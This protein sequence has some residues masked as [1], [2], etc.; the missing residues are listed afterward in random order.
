M[1]LLPIITPSA[2]LM[3]Q[4]PRSS[5]TGQITGQVIEF[6]LKD[7]CNCGLEKTLKHHQDQKTINTR[8][9]QGILIADNTQAYKLGSLCGESQECCF[10]T[11]QFS[12]EA[13]TAQVQPC[14]KRSFNQYC[15]RSC[16]ILSDAAG[17]MRQVVDLFCGFV[18][19]WSKQANIGFPRICC[20]YVP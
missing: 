7:L 10:G 18:I 11:N 15:G 3:Q 8:I 6:I 20:C 17:F 9:T 19:I 1:C 2:H 14:F 5:P 4:G 12:S 16:G 13:N